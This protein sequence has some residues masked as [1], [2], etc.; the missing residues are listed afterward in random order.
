ME[1][2]ISIWFMAHLPN[3]SPGIAPSQLGSA[4]SPPSKPRRRG[5]SIA[6]LPP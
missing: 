6:T 1:F 4:C 3:Q 2:L 5:R